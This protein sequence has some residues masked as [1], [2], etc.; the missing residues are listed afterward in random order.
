MAKQKI[1][2]TID[3]NDY[4]FLRQKAEE[5]ELS[6]TE[7]VREILKIYVVG[8]KCPVMIKNLTEITKE[9][10]RNKKNKD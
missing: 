4:D 10:L 3:K 5:K 7:L 6:V 2:L 8:M 9:F 1:A